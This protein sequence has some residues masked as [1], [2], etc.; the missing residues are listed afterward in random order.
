M[1]N[2][3]SSIKAKRKPKKT[4]RQTKLKNPQRKNKENHTQVKYWIKNP[5]KF[6]SSEVH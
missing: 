3:I 2:I 4:N 1:K 5:I 6:G